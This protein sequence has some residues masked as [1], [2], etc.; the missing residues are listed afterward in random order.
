MF[1]LNDLP[2]EPTA[3]EPFISAKTLEFHHG[4]HHQTYVDNLNKLTA[5]TPF[6]HNSLEQIIVKTAGR[7]DKQGVFNN[8]AQVYNHDFFWKSLQPAD[9]E[10]LIP[11]ELKN[12]V[13][14][15]FKS[16]ENMIEE[17]KAAALAQFGSGWVWLVKEDDNVKIVKTANADTPIAHG[18][19]PLL[20]IDVWEHA[21]YLDYQ[22]KRLDFV[23]AIIEHLAN[24]EFALDNLKA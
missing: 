7:D 11:V 3:L 10:Q 22:N 15:S 12:A 1:T 5:G 9:R 6:E 20:T 21:Y 17:L 13:I 14:H 18:Q 2:F 23:T 16:W 24:W 8:A 4:K 19:K